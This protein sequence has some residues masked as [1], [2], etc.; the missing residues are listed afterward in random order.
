MIDT[1]PLW[2]AIP[3]AILLVIGG[4]VT[5]TGSLGLLRLPTFYMRIHA[6][7]LGNTMGVFCVL[8]ASILVSSTLEQ[9]LVVHQVLI[10][11]FLVITS[12]VT[13]MLLMRAAIRRQLRVE[14]KS[15]DGS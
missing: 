1:L 12:P 2:V 15:A 10:T 13:A 9:R 8:L 3:S 4:I 5:L 7:T 14:Q 6:P 11:L